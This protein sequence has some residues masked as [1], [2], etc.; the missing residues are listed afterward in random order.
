MSKNQNGFTYVEIILSTLVVGVLLLTGWYVYSKQTNNK[1]QQ[2][3]KLSSD[4]NIKPQISNYGVL[5][6]TPVNPIIIPSDWVT[7]NSDIDFTVKVP[8]E[9]VQNNLDT[10]S[11]TNNI[12]SIAQTNIGLV[13]PN[14]ITGYYSKNPIISSNDSD[15][16]SPVILLSNQHRTDKGGES[17][18]NKLEANAQNFSSLYSINESLVSIGQVKINNIT[19]VQ[20]DYLITGLYMRTVYLWHNDYAI[21]LTIRDP[22]LSRMNTLTKNYLYPIAASVIFKS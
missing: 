21:V 10:A 14:S 22:N 13:I 5:G 9:F 16:S 19:W 7:Y 1:I 12:G 20:Q 4:V 17:A 18:F 3:S 8:N 15:N 11:S 6:T 2:S